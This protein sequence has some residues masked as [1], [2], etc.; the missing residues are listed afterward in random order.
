MTK[1]ILKGCLPRCFVL[2]GQGAV[3]QILSVCCAGRRLMKKVQ[4]QTSCVKVLI[5]LHI[6]RLL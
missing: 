6:C 5:L 1:D 2:L 3:R 4:K